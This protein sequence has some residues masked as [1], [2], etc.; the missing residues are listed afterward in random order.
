MNPEY[1]I[2]EHSHVE[3]SDERLHREAETVSHLRKV[4]PYVGER[5]IQMALR[6][7]LTMQEQIWR[8]AERHSNE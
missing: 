5:A 7:D 4:V 8:Y 2:H 1:N 6:A 3:W